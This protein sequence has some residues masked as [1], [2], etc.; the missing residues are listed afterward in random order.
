MI[1]RKIER[2][3]GMEGAETARE[4]GLEPPQREGI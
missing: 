1:Y 3:T 4:A 2:V